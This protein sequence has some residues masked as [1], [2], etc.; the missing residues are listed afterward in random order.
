MFRIED[1]EKEVMLPPLAQSAVYLDL[2]PAS[3]R[4]YNVMQAMLALN[5]VDSERAD[6]V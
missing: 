1:V 3:M 5:A 6:A 4:S 2:E